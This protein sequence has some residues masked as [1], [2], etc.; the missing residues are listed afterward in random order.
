M[1]PPRP[2]PKPALGRA[3]TPLAPAHFQRRGF[4]VVT[5][6][7]PG[8]DSPSGSLG[9]RRPLPCPQPGAALRGSGGAAVTR[10]AE[11]AASA[12]GCHRS[13][14]LGD[15]AARPV[16]VGRRRET[17]SAGPS[18][19]D[20]WI[21]CWARCSQRWTRKGQAGGPGRCLVSVLFHFP[22]HGMGY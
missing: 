9:P 4:E 3:Y 20:D 15:L 8:V 18:C 17:S 1:R 2:P 14:S 11:R 5:S 6:A 21:G 10:P 13:C 22:V 19:W 12:R 7:P 16:P